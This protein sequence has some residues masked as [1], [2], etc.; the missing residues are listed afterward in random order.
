MMNFTVNG[1]SKNGNSY[2]VKV[3]PKSILFKSSPTY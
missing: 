1:A 2:Q 3:N